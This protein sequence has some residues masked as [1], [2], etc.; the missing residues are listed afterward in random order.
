MKPGF[1]KR[2]SAYLIDIVLVS[3][4]A[5]IISVGI[6]TNTDKYTE[7]L[8]TLMTDYMNGEV[9]MEEYLSK[10][11]DLNYEIQKRSVIPNTINLVVTVGYFIVFAY[12]NKGQTIGKKLLKIKVVA[13]DTNDA[14]SLVAITIRSILILGIISSLCQVIL[15][16]FLSKTS[17]FYTSNIITGIEEII[18][19]I[20]AFFILYRS[21]KN[22]IH[23]LIAKTEV[24]SE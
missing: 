12:L 23:D 24:V 20:S 7:E 15:I 16:N 18:L 11:E 14:P 17:Y 6:N 10:T 21:D 2:L 1:L 4:V 9:T 13:K 8:S 19:I 22:G 5:S 3:I